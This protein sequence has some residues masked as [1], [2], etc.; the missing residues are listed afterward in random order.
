MIR[1]PIGRVDKSEFVN[2]N[3][4]GSSEYGLVHHEQADHLTAMA[5][6]YVQR[7]H[8]EIAATEWH[9]GLVIADTILPWTAEYLLHY[10]YSQATGRWHGG[11][12]EPPPTESGE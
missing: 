8:W 5:W 9:D 10:E 6:D 7:G 1:R 11:G 3:N 12:H 2:G 4:V